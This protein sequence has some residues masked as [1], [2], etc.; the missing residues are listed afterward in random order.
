MDSYRGRHL[1][2]GWSGRHGASLCRPGQGIDGRKPACADAFVARIG[3]VALPAA[4][5]RLKHQEWY[6]VRNACKLLGE[7]KDPELLQHIAPVFE[8]QDERVQKAALQAVKDSKLPRRAAVI[9]NALPLLSPQLVEDALCE[10]MHQADP[11][12]L[13]GLENYFS[14]SAAK[15]ARTLR[16]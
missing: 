1:T 7:L 6:V 2:L 16:L 13:P 14:S 5:Q 15:S 11:E 10:L 4:R 8:H 9:A 12:G 3:P